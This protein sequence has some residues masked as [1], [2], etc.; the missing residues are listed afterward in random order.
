MKL[1]FF[2]RADILGQPVSLTVG[3]SESHQ[4]Y[5]GAVLSLLYLAAIAIVVFFVGRGMIDT[6]NPSVIQTIEQSMD[7]PSMDLKASH[8]L[9][10]ILVIDPTGS[11]IAEDQL[12]RYLRFFGRRFHRSSIGGSSQFKMDIIPLLKCAELPEPTF[13]KYYGLHKERPGNV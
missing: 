1:D 13:D 11:A 6:S 12:N 7:F 5:C 10:I 4:T 2:K 3:D 9:P 8:M